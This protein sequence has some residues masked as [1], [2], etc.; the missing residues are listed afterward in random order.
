MTIVTEDLNGTVK[1]GIVGEGL[2][3]NPECIGYLIRCIETYRLCVI[4]SYKLTGNI[5]RKTVSLA[6]SVCHIND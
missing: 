1:E 5:T 2:K 3:R 6:P 4:Q